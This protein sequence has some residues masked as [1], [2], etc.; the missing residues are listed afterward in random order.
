[1]H[2]IY[3][4]TKGENEDGK[5]VNLVCD[6]FEIIRRIFGRNTRAMHYSISCSNSDVELGY[7][8][9]VKRSISEEDDIG[10]LF[11]NKFRSITDTSISKLKYEN[12]QISKVD[13]VNILCNVFFVDMRE[14]ITKLLTVNTKSED[15]GNIIKRIFEKEANNDKI[16]EYTLVTEAECLLSI[17][18]SLSDNFE[19]EFIQIDDADDLEFAIKGFFIALKVIVEMVHCP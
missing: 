2:R 8:I 5:Y 11:E 1:M 15:F 14:E 19:E 18:L 10:I 16:N 12:R 17:A 4:F 6:I 3:S 7:T 9:V 13:I